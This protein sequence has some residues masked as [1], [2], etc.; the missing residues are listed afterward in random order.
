MNYIKK[1]TDEDFNLKTKEA[2][3]KD[4][5]TFANKKVEKKELFDYDWLNEE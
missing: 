3:M 1:L 4:K 2:I 5:M